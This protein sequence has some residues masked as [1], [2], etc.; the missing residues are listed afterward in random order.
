MHHFLIFKKFTAIASFSS[1][2]LLSVVWSKVFPS[3]VTIYSK[4]VHSPASQHSFACLPEPSVG[5]SHALCLV[6]FRLFGRN[7][8]ASNRA[9]KPVRSGAE[10]DRLWHTTN[11]FFVYSN[12]LYVLRAQVVLSD[13]FLKLTNGF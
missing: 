2:R 10:F 5:R 13:C 9:L 6:Y 8:P 12:S 3:L 11:A 1:F 7:H 4:N